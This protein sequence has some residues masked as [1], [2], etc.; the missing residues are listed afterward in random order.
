M[1]ANNLKQQPKQHLQPANKAQQMRAA[2]Y[3][4]QHSDSE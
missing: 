2:F 4:P 3:T 1:Q